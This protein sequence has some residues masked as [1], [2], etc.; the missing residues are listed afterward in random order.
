MSSHLYE[1]QLLERLA[2]IPELAQSGFQVRAGLTGAGVTL[3]RGR[4]YFGAWR[5]S[6]GS[7]VWTYSSSG[8]S[9]YFAASIEDATRYTMLVVLRSLET[10]RAARIRPQAMAG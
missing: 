8:D 6:F 7:L 1:Q 9:S 4:S 3:L 5:N 2:E 10:S